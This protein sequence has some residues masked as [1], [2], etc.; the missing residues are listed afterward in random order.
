MTDHLLFLTPLTHP[1]AL[2]CLRSSRSKYAS[3][4]LFCFFVYFSLMFLYFKLS[5]SRFK[6]NRDHTQTF[7]HENLLHHCGLGLSH[8]RHSQNSIW[9]VQTVIQALREQQQQSHSQ[10]TT[11]LQPKNNR[12]TY[13][14]K[15]QKTYSQKTTE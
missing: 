4:G 3:T 1:L 5:R 7:M 15:K 11:E 14:R 13:S 9:L 2:L 6:K 8:S 12:I 10:K